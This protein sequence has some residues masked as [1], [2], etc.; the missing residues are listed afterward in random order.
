MTIPITLRRLRRMTNL[1]C[2]TDGRWEQALRLC[3][4]EP[5]PS[6]TAI[7]SWVGSSADFAIE[8]FFA[9]TQG[10]PH[11]VG[12]RWIGRDASQVADLVAKAHDVLERYCGRPA[13]EVLAAFDAALG[14]RLLHDA[15]AFL[16]IGVNNLWK[17]VG[18]LV[19]WRRGERIPARDELEAKLRRQA[20]QLLCGQP[21]E[22]MLEIGYVDPQ[23][24]WVGLYTSRRQGDQY[25]LD[26]DQGLKLALEF[27]D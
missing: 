20:P 22:I 16:E 3:P 7:A 15:P 19:I 27:G 11:F 26:L 2:A 24:H 1:Q 23:P 12:V 10:D 21:K 18:S 4:G 13:D 25:L 17:S 14:S 5:C 9:D 8:M 6:P